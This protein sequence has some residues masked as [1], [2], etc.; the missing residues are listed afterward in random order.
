LTGK[1][2][3]EADGKIFPVSGQIPKQVRDDVLIKIFRLSKR[4]AELV[5][6]SQLIS[7]KHQKAAPFLGKRLLYVAP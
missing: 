7:F 5:S 1:S 3:S 6:A 4:H 2:L